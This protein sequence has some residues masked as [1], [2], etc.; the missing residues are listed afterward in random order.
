MADIAA[1]APAALYVVVMDGYT[2]DDA[3]YSLP[4]RVSRDEAIRVC[5]DANETAQRLGLSGRWHA[6]CVE[7]A[8]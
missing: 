8:S 5:D 1:P 4:G 6:E 7:V 2:A 3:T